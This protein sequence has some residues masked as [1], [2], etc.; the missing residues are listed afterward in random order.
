MQPFHEVVSRIRFA[1]GEDPAD[2]TVVVVD[3]LDGDARG[4]LEI[5]LTEYL[6]GEVPEHRVRALRRGGLVVWERPLRS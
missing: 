6:E 2:Y 5:P 1:P 3:R 4:L